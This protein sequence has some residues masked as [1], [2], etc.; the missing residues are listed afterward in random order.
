MRKAIILLLGILFA[1]SAM[2]QDRTVTGVVTDAET[3]D[4]LPGV[5]VVLVG[6]TIGAATNAEGEYSVRIPGGYNT[7][8]FSFVGY[9]TQRVPIDDRTEI[10]IQMQPDI[11]QLDDVFVVGYGEMS[12]REITSSIS[13][14]SSEDFADLSLVTFEEALQGRVSGVQMTST[15]GVLGAPSA[16]R[17]RGAAS[18][19]ASTTPLVVIDGVPVTNPTTAGSASVGLAAGGQGINPLLNIN[20]NDIESIEV[21]KDAA[22][23]AIYGSQGSNGVI[24]ITTKQGRPDQQVIN[25]RTYAGTVTETNNYDMMD[26]HEFTRIWNDAGVNWLEHTGLDNLLNQFGFPGDAEELWFGGATAVLFGADASLDPDNVV[27]TNWMDLVSQTGYLTETSASVRGGTQRT[28]YFVSGTYRWEEGFTRR[29][30][31][32]RY[33]G[34]ARLSHNISDKVRVGVNLSPSRTDNFRVYTSNAVAAPF[35]YAALHYPNI[36]ARDEDGEF[37]L[38]VAPNIFSTFSGTPLSNVEGIDFKSSLTQLLGSA[39]LAWNILPRLAFNTEFSVDL[40]QLAEE[41]KRATFTTDGF[42]DGNAFASNNQFVNY[43]LNTTLA[44]SERAGDHQYSVMGGVTAQHSDNSYFDVF[45]RAFPNDAVKTVSSAATPVGV[46]GTGT[47]FSFLGFLS[48]ATYS[49]LDRYFVTFTGRIDG[50][51]RFSEDNRFGFF[52]SVSAGWIVS[53]ESWLRGN[54][55]IDFLKLRASVGQTGNANIGNFASLGLVG[56]GFDYDGIPGGRIVQLDNPDL[57]WEKTTQFD[58]A[59]EFGFFG[60]RLRGSIGYYLKDTDDLLLNVPISRVNGFVNFT[61]NVGAV[62]NSGLELELTA[63]IF[64]RGDFKWTFSANVSTVENEVKTLVD[65]EDMIFGRNIVREGEP[66]GAFYLVRYNGPNPENG[67]ATWLTLDGEVTES[68]ST[69]HRVIAGD[70]FPD[71]F[72]G[73]TNTFAYGPVDLNI[74]FQFSYGNDMYRGDGP[75]TDS[76]LNSVFNQ[77]KRMNDYWTPDNPDAA[78]PRPILF[79]ANGS[80]HSTRYLEDASYLRLKQA[81]IGYT[82]PATWTRAVRARIYAQGQNLLTFTNF[83]GMDPEA[84]TAG[85]IQQQDVFFQLPQPKTLVFGVDLTF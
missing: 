17:I 57:R 1:V 60:S 29:N 75:F 70:P 39:D 56:F 59:V 3:G 4:P 11:L 42:P 25:V 32:F 84:A 14:I 20:P 62:Q 79:T 83:D 36:P 40:F 7:L 15:S 8:Q 66:L 51:S 54:P 13:R 63:D 52:P 58:T 23:S 73:F 55:F 10:N 5:S 69:A 31:L 67:N 44:Y 22:A 81:T 6:T 45:A 65:G 9:T 16:I 33:S 49:Y 71:Y 41:F 48:R 18:I 80:Q 12:R 74:F 35:T 47:S 72:G 38:S 2:A 21:L 53:D 26:G 85:N 34:R 82:L 78:H 19:S 43:N 64:H 77:S 28:Q 50:S 46:S 27:S 30:E 61:Q 37:N 68:Y 24:L 76:N